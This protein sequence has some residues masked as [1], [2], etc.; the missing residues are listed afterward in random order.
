MNVNEVFSSAQLE[1]VN[2]GVPCTFIRFAK[3]NLRCDWCD[4]KYAFK[5]EVWTLARMQQKIQELGHN[6]IVFTGGEPLLQ[7]EAIR[8]IINSFPHYYYEIETNG[9]IDPGN[10]LFRDINLFTVSPKL[11]SSLMEK[12]RR[13]IPEILKK[14]VMWSTIIQGKDVYFKFVIKTKEDWEEMEDL[15]KEYQI[16]SYNVIVMP[17]ATTIK[18]MR[19]RRWVFWNAIKKGYRFSLRGQT[20]LF[21]KRRG[22]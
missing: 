21:G 14:F 8:L 3:C 12:D 19:S 16:Q 4:T 15:I 1:G 18:E 11:S 5:G 20:I 10:E 7:K 17:C 6:H 2:F 9:T 13:I 22:V